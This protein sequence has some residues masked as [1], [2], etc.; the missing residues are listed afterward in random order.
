MVPSYRSVG[1][2]LWIHSGEQYHAPFKFSP[3]TCAATIH[4]SDVRSN[5]VHGGGAVGAR[6]PRP[7]SQSAFPL[8]TLRAKTTNQNRPNYILLPDAR[9][10]P[11]Y[12]PMILR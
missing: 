4:S 1:L 11:Q 8:P 5:S 9:S 3:H 10:H 12:T 6:E 7:R 2:T